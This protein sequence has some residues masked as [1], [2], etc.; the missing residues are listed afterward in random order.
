M[1]AFQ[2]MVRLFQQ[3]VQMFQEIEK[4]D[5]LFDVTARVMH[6]FYLSLCKAGFT[7]EQAAQI[8]AAQGTG[9]IA[10]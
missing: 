6:K 5:E 1:D 9:I 7:E 3:T 8:V 2:Q 4:Q 10:K